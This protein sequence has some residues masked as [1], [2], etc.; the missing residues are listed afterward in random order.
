MSA[1]SI[2]LIG[3]PGAGKTSVG[4]VLAERLNQPLTDSDH[5]IAERYG[6]P[7]GDV[8]A[9]LTEPGFREVEVDAVAAAVAAGGVVSL[10]GGAVTTPANRAL[11]SRLAAAGTPVVWLDVDAAEAV[12]R[13]APEASRPILDSADPLAHYQQLLDTRREFYREV[14][15]LR[16]DTTGV[17]TTAIAATILSAIDPHENTPMRTITVHGTP[18]YDVL[19]G[20]HLT[21]QIVDLATSL[22]QATKAL[23]ITQPTVRD[24][25]D[26]LAGEL[27]AAG[28]ASA[29]VAEIPDAE[30][31]KTIDVAR[32]LWELC[33]SELIGRADL[34]IG[35]GGGAATDLAGFIAATW[36]RGI[37]WIAV[38]TS[39]LGMV[40]AAVGGKTGIN[41]ESGK[42]LVGSFYPP[43]GV[44]ADIDALRTLPEAELINGM[45]EVIKCG[46][47]AD[48][49]ILTT[50]AADPTAALSID[51]QLPDLIARAIQVK[52]DV[53]GHD[54]RESGLREILNY[55]HTFAHAI[56]LEED[57]QW[58]HGQAVA[59]GMMFIAYL[60]ESYGLI[61]A[62]LVEVH[63]RLL[64][65]VGL[66][67][68]Y[69]PGKFDNL[70][71]HML[72]D[73]KNRAGTLRF[74][75]LDGEPGHVTR[76]E[77]PS[78]EKLRA[79]YHRCV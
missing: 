42:N 1:T 32:R 27:T 37:A 3:P 64:S 55:G 47:I 79:A 63:R 31:G 48:P 50:V 28:F 57:Y 21:G 40:D 68:T 75:A 58:R 77:G 71:D 14:A 23:I 30:A 78:E 24:R 76:L 39:L 54:L 65:S 8:F 17:N 16:V 43:L 26:A 11:L 67:T 34:I 29:I 44:L 36:M 9:E 53:V 13:T 12:R 62:Q 56:E 59:V 66:A 6:K 74:V 46:F 60:A 2:I 49:T 25:A 70:L 10:G 5:L 19:I 61:D 72:R 73:K 15:T 22:P 45:G 35:V 7:C 38:P 41:T 51:G 20:E 4:R 52:A 69:T 33:G 18:D